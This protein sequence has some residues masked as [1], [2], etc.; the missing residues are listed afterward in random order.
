MSQVTFANE[1]RDVSPVYDIMVQDSPLL[2]GSV[3]Q[4]GAVR[5]TKAEWQEI[6]TA[7]ISDT[8]SAVST[9]LITI[10]DTSQFKVGDLV[11]FTASTGASLAEKCLV[12]VLDS[13]TTMTLTRE[14]AGTTGITLASGQNVILQ[15][16]PQSNGSSAETGDNS[17]PSLEYNYTEIMDETAE[18]TKTDQ[19]V[20]SYSWAD[21][22]A[23]QEQQAIGRL[24]RKQNNALIWGNRF[25]SGTKRSMGGVLEYLDQGD[26]NVVAGGAGAISASLIN[27]GF[28][29]IADAGGIAKNYVLLC[30]IAQSQKISA[31]NSSDLQ[32]QQGSGTTG[33]LVT[34]FRSDIAMGTGFTARVLVDNNMSNDQLA[35]LDLDKITFNPLQGRQMTASPASGNGDD[36]LRTRILGEYTSILRDA[37]T[38]H[39]LIDNIAL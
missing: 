36:Y 20:S 8:L 14:Y 13:A 2:I 6:S 27:A 37:K 22:M 24:I 33:E 7:P 29:L 31:F 3:A 10:S 34:S 11:R 18:V 32:V 28:K 35:I 9:N 21:N 17:E 19:A 39:A 15:S 1:I 30:N 12:A 23:W 25:E 16:R 5:N 4:G 26:G 38:G